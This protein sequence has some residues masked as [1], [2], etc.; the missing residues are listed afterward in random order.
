MS[1]LP[2]I[3]IPYYKLRYLDAAL[4]SL[5]TQTRSGFKVFIG[6]DASPE[7]PREIIG[8]YQGRLDIQYRRFAE[9]LGGVS[10]AGHWN[11]CVHETNSEWVWLFSDDDLAGPDCMDAFAGTLA[12]TAGSFDVYLFD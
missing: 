10:L 5:A 6:D 1:D 12:E 11:R 3:V 4:G 2:T 8:K 9:N 7:D